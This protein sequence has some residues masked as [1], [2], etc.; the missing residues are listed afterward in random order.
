MTSFTRWKAAAQSSPLNIDQLITAFVDGDEQH[1]GKVQIEQANAKAA[2]L[3]TLEQRRKGV[4]AEGAQKKLGV[5]VDPSNKFAFSRASELHNQIDMQRA[6]ARYSEQDLLKLDSAVDA[7]LG[8][9]N[10]E[11][12]RQRVQ[13]EEMLSRG[14][15]PI[16]GEGSGPNQNAARID[17]YYQSFEK[18]LR[19]YIGS[20]ADG[21]IG[22]QF[23]KSASEDLEKFRSSFFVGTPSETC[24]KAG[25]SYTC[26]IAG[27]FKLGTLK[28]EVQRIM[29]A[30]VS[31][32]EKNYRFILGYEET[33]NEV[34][35]FMIDSI[36]AEFVNSGFKVIA[37]GAEEQAEARGDF[38]Y[39]LNILDVNY[40]DN[41]SDVGSV[42]GAGASVF[43]N[44]VLKVRVKL[45]DNNKDVSARQELANVPLINTKRLPR[46]TQMP[47]EA[48]R[49]QLL[50]AQA[51]ELAR[52]VYSEINARPLTIVASQ[53]AT[54]SADHT[55]LA[56]QYSITIAGL[57]QRDRER[58]RA[59]RNA[60]TKA[61]PGTSTTVDL[62]GTNEKSVEIHFDHPEKFDP[63]DLVDAVYA[64]FKDIKTFR[65]HYEGNNAFVGSL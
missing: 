60:V 63:E 62:E 16:S 51:K 14:E 65:V 40:D 59:L 49:S 11:I 15:M 58:I 44:Y 64:I 43:E 47:K 57:T 5:L 25:Y 17:A 3:A 54:T 7:L 41:Q 23:K 42:G 13:R 2:R 31:A 34:T 61:L 39:Y 28:G 21:D 8:A 27:V 10:A 6:N 33:D 9:N 52:Q 38:D 36:R 32:R 53:E 26:S 37:R 35:R 48:R 56:E 29:S 1:I 55:K 19:D 50:P 20:Q 45:L 4:I 22:Q 46:D 30:A 12:E 24:R 18:Q